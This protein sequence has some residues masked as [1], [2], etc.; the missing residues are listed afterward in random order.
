MC[1]LINPSLAHHNTALGRALW[2]R[3]RTVYS[4]LKIN[5]YKPSALFTDGSLCRRL[6]LHVVNN[7]KI[8]TVSLLSHGPMVPLQRFVLNPTR[9][10]G[11]L[12]RI[13]KAQFEVTR[14]EVRRNQCSKLKE[15]I[16]ST[17]VVQNHRLN[18]RR[19]LAP[20][21]Q[22]IAHSWVLL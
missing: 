12:P 9:F 1:K 2:T 15:S 8:H 16:Q 10:S 6:G 4:Q 13:V 18:S 20:H 7:N 14:L 22:Y 3:T 21:H 17:A 5:D 19:Q 11:A